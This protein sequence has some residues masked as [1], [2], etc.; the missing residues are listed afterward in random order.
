MIDFRLPTFHWCHGKITWTDFF[1]HLQITFP[2]HQLLL[3]SRRR[4]RHSW[5][6]GHLARDS[7]TSYP[8]KLPR[9]WR[10]IPTRSPLQKKMGQDQVIKKKSTMIFYFKRIFS[11]D[12]DDYDI[13]P[14]FEVE[15][16][17][18]WLKK[19]WVI[20]VERKIE[21]IWPSKWLFKK[22]TSQTGV[23]KEVFV[24]LCN[25]HRLES[26]T[27]PK[28]L[29]FFHCSPVPQAIPTLIPPCFKGAAFRSSGLRLRALAVAVVAAAVAEGVVLEVLAVACKSWRFFNLFLL[30]ELVIIVGFPSKISGE[31][32][33]LSKKLEIFWGGTV[34]FVC[35]WR[36][37]V[38]QSIAQTSGGTFSKA[39]NH[40][41]SLFTQNC[42]G[43][44]WRSF[45][46]TSARACEQS[47]AKK[48]HYILTDKETPFHNLSTKGHWNH[49][50]TIPLFASNIFQST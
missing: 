8:S 44:F 50:G 31:Y 40:A 26:P 13:A 35:I 42:S 39:T 34:H 3:L 21:T 48:T 12:V 24:K 49:V 33:M 16:K 43:L 9:I 30:G 15:V 10:R 14:F 23:D 38:F 7:K 6:W 4:L 17:G 2:Q 28:Q 25:Y 45:W 27:Y 5:C 1:D 11:L 22:K 37:I 47:F 41:L 19:I 32:V 46:M 36:L 20:F 29:G 18:L